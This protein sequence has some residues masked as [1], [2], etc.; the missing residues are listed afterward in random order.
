[1]QQQLASQEELS[2]HPNQRLA[3]KSSAGSPA[4]DVLARYLSWLAADARH[5]QVANAPERLAK[6]R[7]LATHPVI[8][9]GQ[10]VRTFAPFHQQHSARQTLTPGQALAL[11]ALLLVIIGGGIVFRATMAVA[12]MAVITLFYLGDLLLHLSLAL[13]AL[14]QPTEEQIADEVVH[15]LARANWPRYTILCPLYREATIMPQFAQAMLALDYPVDK[16]EI[17]LVTEEDD[18][19]TRTAIHALNLPDQF[20]LLTVPA[21]HPRTKP[22]ACNFGLLHATGD[23]TVIYDAEDIPDPLQLKKAVLT[24]ANHGPDLAC[25][26]AKL[27]FYNPSHNLLTR[28]FTAEYSSW[29]DL[30]LPGLQRGQLPLPLGGTSNHFRTEILRLLGGWDAFNVTEDCEMGL[31]LH[32]YH[33]QVAMLDSTTYEEAPSHLNNWL[34]QRSRWIKGYLQTYLVHM[35]HPLRDLRQGRLNELLWLQVVLGSKTVILFVNPFMWLLLGV[36]LALRPIVGGV[37]AFLFPPPILYLASI[38]FIFGNFFY[39]YTFLMGCLKRGHYGLIKWA[40]AVP[41]YWALMSIAA[42]IALYKLIAKP[43]FWEKT[44]HGFHLHTPPQKQGGPR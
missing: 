36:Y 28:W 37:Y 40:L 14:A 27:N 17:L 31:R 26:Q 44:L 3:K 34:R 11:L 19:Q 32:H 25:V 23:Y 7:D 10:P 43:H 2:S 15:V 9:R 20:H 21:G 24:F 13:R 5:N 39:L 41:L 35:R 6:Y 30:I 1:M 38:C 8:V 42:F 22:R 12:L 16:L 29:F 4:R 18:A 33:L